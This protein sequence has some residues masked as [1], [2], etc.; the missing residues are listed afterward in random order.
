MKAIFYSLT[1]LLCLLFF[2]SSCQSP[3]TQASDQPSETLSEPDMG[4][5]AKDFLASMSEA[6]LE[7]A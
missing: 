4:N 1:G 3:T 2:L 6:Q 7:K 5:L